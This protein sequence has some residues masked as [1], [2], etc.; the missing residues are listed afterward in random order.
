MPARQPL[1]LMTFRYNLLYRYCGRLVVFLSYLMT[2]YNIAISF[3]PSVMVCP[4]IIPF[5][6]YTEI[7]GDQVIYISC[8]RQVFKGTR[9]S[10]ADVFVLASGDIPSLEISRYIGVDLFLEFHTVIQ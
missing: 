7:H 3:W 2:L 8:V 10:S 6:V 9:K 5:C 4:V 1:C